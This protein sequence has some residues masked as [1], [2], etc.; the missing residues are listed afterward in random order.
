MKELQ[1]L[2]EVVNK[3]RSGCQEC[4]GARGNGAFGRQQADQGQRDAGEEVR[5]DLT[6][7]DVRGGSS[8]EVRG[9]GTVTGATVDSTGPGQGSIF[10][11]INQSPSTMQEMQVR[12]SSV[13]LKTKTI[14]NNWKI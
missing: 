2:K 9:D 3:L 7:Q 4:R 10:G 1:S 12:G 8:Q 11:K 6:G 5:L 14:H 13:S